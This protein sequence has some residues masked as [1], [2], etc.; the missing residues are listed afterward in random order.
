MDPGQ[1]LHDLYEVVYG[2]FPLHATAIINLQGEERSEL[3]GSRKSS[4]TFPDHRLG[5]RERLGSTHLAQPG[6]LSGIVKD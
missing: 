3:G 4:R 6:F 2:G 5:G 1:L